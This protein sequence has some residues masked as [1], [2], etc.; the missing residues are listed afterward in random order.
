MIVPFDKKHPPGDGKKIGCA[1][2]R[3]HRAQENMR[4]E[5][6]MSNNRTLLSLRGWQTVPGGDRVASRLLDNRTKPRLLR[7]NPATRRRAARQ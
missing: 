2:A 7:V 3:E 4:R 1:A 5:G 6:R